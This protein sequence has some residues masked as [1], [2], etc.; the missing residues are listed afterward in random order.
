MIFISLVKIYSTGYFCNAKVAGLGEIFCPVK[1]YGY[2]V[3]ISVMY[4]HSTA[5]LI[6]LGCCS[7]LGLISMK[8]R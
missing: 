5:G 8:R 2:M 6:Y 3:L 1:I 7:L 4:V